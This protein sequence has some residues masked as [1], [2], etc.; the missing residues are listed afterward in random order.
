MHQNI[1]F[2]SKKLI[3]VMYC[4]DDLQFYATVM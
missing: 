4:I 3:V 1:Q 2:H